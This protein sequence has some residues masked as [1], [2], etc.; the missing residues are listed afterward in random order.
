[1]APPAAYCRRDHPVYRWMKAWKIGKRFFYH[2]IDR[3]ASAM[4]DQV[5]CDGQVV[6][7]VT[8][9]GSL[10]EQDAHGPIAAPET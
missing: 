3:C 7:D 2:P 4:A 9:G 5:A 8:E 1:M 10:D 6:N